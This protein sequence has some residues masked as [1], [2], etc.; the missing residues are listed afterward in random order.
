MNEQNIDVTY[1]V[2]QAINNA[3]PYKGFFIGTMSL[4]GDSRFVTYLFDANMKELQDSICDIA[5]MKEYVDVLI[6]FGANNV[7]SN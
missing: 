7:R 6:K 1:T 5:D 4:R 3:K 2:Q